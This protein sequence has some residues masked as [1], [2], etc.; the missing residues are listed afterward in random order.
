VK[1]KKQTITME[2]LRKEFLKEREMMKEVMKTVVIDRP[3]KTPPPP[4]PP[5]IVAKMTIDPEKLEM[6]IKKACVPIPK[7]EITV[8]DKP[9]AV[10]VTT[11]PTGA[12]VAKPVAAL[13]KALNLN[14]TPCKFRAKK[15][16]F[17]AKHAH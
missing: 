12:V 4:P 5:S 1:L 9:P 6:S 14:G 7:R 10:A 3:K 13:C 17:C 15:G 2:K 8:L 16:H 11:A